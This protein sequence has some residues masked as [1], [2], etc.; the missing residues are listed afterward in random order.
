MWTHSTAI[1][2]NNPLKR[3]EVSQSLKDLMGYTLEVKPSQI[4]H[5]DAGQGLF[6][7]GEADVGTVLAFYPG[8]IYSPAYY[9]YIPGYPRVDA[10]N[11]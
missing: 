11:S 2:E 10:Q 5:E 6:I 3:L 7:H 8:V 1:P 4:P 9:R